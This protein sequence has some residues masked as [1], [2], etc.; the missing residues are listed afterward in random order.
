M[1]DVWLFS[2]V[3]GSQFNLYGAYL[4]SHRSREVYW[5][6]KTCDRWF[7]YD[8]TNGN[9]FYIPARNTTACRGTVGEIQVMKWFGVISVVFT[10]RDEGKLAQV[11]E[12]V[13]YVVASSVVLRIK[14]PM[15]PSLRIMLTRKTRR[16][17]YEI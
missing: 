17:T 9:V 15:F 14:L 7:S 12:A 2:V 5:N 10:A 16:G 4:A 1:G 3:Q 11:A 13:S 6:D 8:S